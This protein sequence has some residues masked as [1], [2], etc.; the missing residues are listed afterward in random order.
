MWIL[1]IGLK[2]CFR[3]TC[4]CRGPVDCSFDY[5]RLG[6]AP[7]RCWF[8]RT[9]N[10]KTTVKLNEGETAQDQ[11]SPPDV[12]DA[13]TLVYLRSGGLPVKAGFACIEN[14][15]SVEHVVVY[16]CES[17]IANLVQML[18]ACAHG[19]PFPSSMFLTA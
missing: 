5:F 2:R 15:S 17:W 16:H 13:P 9:F 19:R 4:G 3:A 8:E 12:K 11:R 7:L 14:L 1:L 6:M 18:G 10:E